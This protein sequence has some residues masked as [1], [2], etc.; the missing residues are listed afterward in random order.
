MK[1]PKSVIFIKKLKTNVCK[2]TNIIQLD[3][4]AIIQGNIGVLHIAYAI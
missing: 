2:I 3:I 4:T 1:M